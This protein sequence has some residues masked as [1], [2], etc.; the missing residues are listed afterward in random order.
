MS[1]GGFL[2]N[3]WNTY[4]TITSLLCFFWFFCF[5]FTFLGNASF[6]FKRN[7]SFLNTLSWYIP[8]LPPMN[9]YPVSNYHPSSIPLSDDALDKSGKG[10]AHSLFTCCNISRQYYY[11]SA[12][13]YIQRS[14]SNTM[15]FHSDSV[16]IPLEGLVWAM[17]WSRIL[18]MFPFLSFTIRLKA[19]SYNSWIRT[20]YFYPSNSWLNLSTSFQ[21]R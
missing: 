11:Y 10:G 2:H 12:L 7:F 13:G 18:K 9:T 1:F 17:S 20:F 6:D 19:E 4:L 3:P 5:R 15:V 8:I 21:V 16:D 14:V